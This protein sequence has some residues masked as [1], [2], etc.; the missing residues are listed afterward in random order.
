MGTRGRTWTSA[1]WLAALLSGC[2]VGND[3][4]ELVLLQ[5]EPL[6]TGTCQGSHDETVGLSSGVIDMAMATDYIL[7]PLAQNNLGGTET[8]EGALDTFDV[9]LRRAIVEYEP[10]D[11]ISVTF[12]DEFRQPLSGH[13][14]AAGG[15]TRF[16]VEV[17]TP[18]MVQDLRTAQEFVVRSADGQVRPARAQIKLLV[19]LTIQGETLD[20]KTVESNR[21][22]FPLT[23]CNGCLVSVPPD[24]VSGAVGTQPNCLNISVDETGKTSVEL[25]DCPGFIGQNEPVDCR[26]CALSAVDDFARQLCQ[27]SF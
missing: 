16:G 27:P 7:F 21:M 22:I 20:G 11:Q 9:L 12:P 1:L 17:L 14:A 2:V 26:V 25:P 3:D 24:A 18:G 10:L 4:G 8:T 13:V 15:Q 6:D 5:A 23:V 19:K